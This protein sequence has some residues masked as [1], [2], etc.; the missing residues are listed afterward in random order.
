MTAAVAS[1]ASSRAST[2]A[3]LPGKA[4]AV[5]VS[6]IGLIAGAESRNANA[7]AGVTPRR[8]R[9]FAT[10][11][12]A[13]SQP[14]RTAPATPA[15]GTASAG[16]LGSTLVN[17]SAGTKALMAPDSAVPSSRKGSACTVMAR[18]TVRQAAT[19][20]SLS[21]GVP[22]ST[23][24]AAARPSA[25]T[26]AA[27]GGGLRRRR[28]RRSGGRTAAGNTVSVTSSSSSVF[29]IFAPNV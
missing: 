1:E 13:H 27:V 12:D 23:R 24:T 8:I 6:T 15:T 25:L 20:G 11:T 19:A 16:C 4:T 21:Q 17:R 7:A 10:G 2:M 18:Q 14:G 29:G 3:G 9:L 28:R 26:T 22:D 5:A